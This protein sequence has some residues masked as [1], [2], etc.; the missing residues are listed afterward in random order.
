LELVEVK[1]VKVVGSP[2]SEATLLLITDE[3]ILEVYGIPFKEAVIIHAYMEKCDCDIVK[4]MESRPRKLA[5][6]VIKELKLLK[7]QIEKIVIMGFEFEGR[8]LFKAGVTFTHGVSTTMIPSQ[9]L[10]FACC[11]EE[12]PKIYI[13]LEDMKAQEARIAEDEA[14]RTKMPPALAAIMK[15]GGRIAIIDGPEPLAGAMYV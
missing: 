8:S 6:L 2:M 9:A 1:E 13:Q 3:G 7:E 15:K 11:Q 14:T 12:L 10:A 5:W 4:V